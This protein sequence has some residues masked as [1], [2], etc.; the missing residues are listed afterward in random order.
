MIH[1][2]TSPSSLLARFAV[3]FADVRVRLL[4]EDGDAIHRAFSVGVPGTSH[5]GIDYSRLCTFVVGPPAVAMAI[6]DRVQREEEARAPRPS[7]AVSAPGVE[8]VP[9]R[10]GPPG[11]RTAGE[12]AVERH[13]AGSEL[14]DDGDAG[15]ALH[16]LPPSTVGGW[17]RTV[18][19]RAEVSSGCLSCHRGCTRRARVCVCECVL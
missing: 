3:L 8:L 15:L 2:L 14:S 9:Y 1:V 19:L 17:L 13:R 16:D 11:S 10:T 4:P 6:L 18:R 7:R 5:S 12:R